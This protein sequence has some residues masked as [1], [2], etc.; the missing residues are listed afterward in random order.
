MV[1][2]EKAWRGL[3]SSNFPPTLLQPQRYAARSILPGALVK[4]K[5]PHLG[6]ECGS[7]LVCAVRLVW[8]RAWDVPVSRTLSPGRNYTPLRNY[9]TPRK[10]DVTQFLCSA[11]V[12][13]DIF[14]F[15]RP[16]VGFGSWWWCCCRA[17]GLAVSSCLRE[18][19]PWPTPN[20]TF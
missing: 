14:T 8:C 5:N 16:R 12:L 3:S 6:G 10:E 17:W 7:G 4:L 19:P 15:P 9:A 1:H 18:A 13:H 20:S 2:H 11:V